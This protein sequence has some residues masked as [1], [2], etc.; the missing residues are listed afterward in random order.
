MNLGASNRPGL[1]GGFMSAWVTLKNGKVLKY[2]ECFYV[3]YDNDKYVLRNKSG[4][5]LLA[6]IPTDNIERFEYTRP[7]RTYRD[8]RRDKL[9][10]IK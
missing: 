9:Q 5:R 3:Q 2:N 8:P 7:C 10:I 6:I 4:G 1:Q